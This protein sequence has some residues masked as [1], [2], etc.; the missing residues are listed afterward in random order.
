[1][2][3]SE[4]SEQGGWRLVSSDAQATKDAA[5]AL[6]PLLCAGDVVT[7]SG[8]LGAG[9]TQFTQGVAAGLGVGAPV[10]SPTFNILLE[11]HDG[12]LPLYHF[13]LYRLDDSSELED[14]GFFETVEGDGATLVEWSEKF[15]EEMP[16]ERLEVA[17]SVAPDASRVL[18]VCGIGERGE[19]LARAWGDRLSGRAGGLA[20][21]P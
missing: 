20:A 15:P 6:A 19:A 16:D 2:D 11:Y 10:T 3:I 8:D 14:V 7:F 5:A 9:K 12:R 13:D 1:M 4:H 18:D 21:L 17:I